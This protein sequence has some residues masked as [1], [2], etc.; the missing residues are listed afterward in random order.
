MSL[1]V[2]DPEKLTAVLERLDRTAIIE[3]VNHQFNKST[4]SGWAN[5]AWKPS[6]KNLDALLKAIGCDFDDI[7]TPYDE[8]VAKQKNPA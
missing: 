3:K 7:S 6:D 4:L 2:L 5:G 8:F 1:R